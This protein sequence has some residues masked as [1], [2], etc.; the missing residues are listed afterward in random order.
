MSS[1]PYGPILL[2]LLLLFIFL[3]IRLE[4]AQDTLSN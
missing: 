1:G 4:Q 2:L 3:H